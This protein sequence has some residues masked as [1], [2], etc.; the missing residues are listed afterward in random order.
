MLQQFPPNSTKVLYQMT[1]RNTTLVR[2][3]IPYSVI[4]S[5][6]MRSSVYMHLT[7]CSKYIIFLANLKQV[8]DKR[9][10]DQ[11]YF[12]IVG[13][14]F[15]KSEQFFCVVDRVSETQLQVSENSK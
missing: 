8:K 13:L 5:Q 7:S 4:F 2:W 1:A 15:A 14:H 12:K 9:D 11:Q 6:N 3:L 10:I